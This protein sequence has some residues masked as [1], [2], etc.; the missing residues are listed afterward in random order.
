[1]RTTAIMN[2]KGGTAKTVTAINTAAIL[3][4]DYGQRVLLIDADSQGNLSEF[5]AKNPEEL[6]GVPGTADLLKGNTALPVETKIPDVQLIP[7][8]ENLMA[9]DVTAVS[10]GSANPMAL[11]DLTDGLGE[12][13]AYDR[14]IID[15]P[16]AFNAAAMAAL[17]AADDVLIPV[18]LDAF[19]I[20]GLAKIMAQ[21]RNMKKINPDLEVAGVLPTMYYS[22]PK[23]KE[24]EEDLRTALQAIGIRCFHHVQRSAS[25]DSSTFEQKPLV[26]FSPTSKAC[27]HYRQFVGE[28][29]GEEAEDDG[30]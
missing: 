24:A 29:M 22:C 14:V 28:L 20:R 9:L 7:G 4:K 25:V 19:G 23:Q 3:S 27:R 30:V 15:C 13:E 26:Y 21:I 5:T 1:M 6:G 18:K 8:D 11:K 12:A 2:L 10:Q 16:P 17:L